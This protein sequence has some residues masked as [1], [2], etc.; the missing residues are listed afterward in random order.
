MAFKLKLMF[1]RLPEES[2]NQYETQKFSWNVGH[3]IREILILNL[4][5][6]N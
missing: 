2:I 1:K 6:I 4:D 3:G 5:R